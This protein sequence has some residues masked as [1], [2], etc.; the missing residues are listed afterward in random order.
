MLLLCK[1][2]ANH[3]FGETSGTCARAGTLTAVLQLKNVSRELL[4]GLSRR[5]QFRTST[6]LAVPTTVPSLPCLVCDISQRS[7]QSII[8][9]L[10]MDRNF[11]LKFKTKLI[12]SFNLKRCVLI[13]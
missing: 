7:H 10:H 6:A 11:H 3:T 1:A 5:P 8:L 12:S 4:H 2:N 9:R 13:K